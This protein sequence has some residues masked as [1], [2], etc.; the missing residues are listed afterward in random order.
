MVKRMGTLGAAVAAFAMAIGLLAPAGAD[1]RYETVT[2]RFAEIAGDNDRL[3][4]DVDGPNVTVG[5]YFVFFNPIFDRSLT[6]R[7]GRATG[8]CLLLEVA[9]EAPAVVECDLTYDLPGGTIAVKGVF[10]LGRRRNE[11]A[12]TGGTDRYRTAHGELQLVQGE[13]GLLFTFKLLL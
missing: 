3:L 2:L 12:V 13:K 4:V 6:K 8:D 1:K 11:F 5:D 9:E 10:D 7:V